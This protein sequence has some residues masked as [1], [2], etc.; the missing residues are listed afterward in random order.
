MIRTTTETLG[1]NR[2]ELFCRVII[3]KPLDDK[4]RNE[5]DSV[6]KKFSKK[7][8]KVNVETTVDPSIMG[9]MIMEIDDRYIDMSI[10]SKI[11][12]YMDILTSNV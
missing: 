4:L 3:A 11:K 6:L 12:A 9:E 7:G 8:E 10:A 2:T 5:F 1:D